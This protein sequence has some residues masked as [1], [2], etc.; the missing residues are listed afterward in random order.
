MAIVTAKRDHKLASLL[1][2][3]NHFQLEEDVIRFTPSRLTKMDQPGPLC[4]PF[5]VKPWKEGLSICP[6]E[7]VRLILQGRG[8]LR[9]THNTIFFSWMHPHNQSLPFNIV[10]F[11]LASRRLPVP[12]D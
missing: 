10:S 12:P 6:V 9:L 4:P 11:K 8:C 3:T 1:S 2:D 5:Y 7:T